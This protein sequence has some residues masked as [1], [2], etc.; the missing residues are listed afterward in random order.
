MGPVDAAALSIV[1]NSLSDYNHC[2]PASSF[3]PPICPTLALADTGASGHYFLPHAP[4]TNINAHAPRTTIRTATGQPLISSGTAA[5]TLRTIPPVSRQAHIVPGLPHNL[6]TIAPLCNAGCT[7]RFTANTLT[8]TDPE[9][10]TILS[11]TRGPNAP[12]L[13]QIDLAP[14]LSPMAL[15]VARPHTART[16]T[17]V[18]PHTLLPKDPGTN[19]TPRHKENL[20]PSPRIHPHLRTHDLPTTQAL[21]AFLHA[22]AG[23]PVKSTWLRAIKNNFYKSWPGLTYTL[24]AKYCPTADATIQG[25]M[26]QPQQHIQSTTHT[27][28]HRQ[29]LPQPPPHTVDIFSIPLNKIFTDDT[30]R[31]HP[32]ARSGN[33]YIMIALHADTN[34]ILVRP[35]PNKHDAH[36]IA[37]YQDIHTRLANANRKPMMHIL[38]NEAS[39]AF[40]QA[41]TSNGCTFQLV[42][43]HVHRRNAAERAIRTFKDHFL[44]ILAGTAPTFPADRWDLLIP[45]AEL[46]LNLLRASHCNPA[47]S[48]WEDLFGPFNFDATPLGPAGCRVLVHNKAT[49]EHSETRRSSIIR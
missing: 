29:T 46:T 15:H 24:I 10:T 23:Y 2:P 28:A 9:G 13:W 1:T 32:R 43:P 36:R 16:P 48:A 22:T 5:T 31:F 45:Q 42:P 4:L 25:H 35:F 26:A 49:A 14:P 11:G 40:Q 34:A 33:Q 12:R 21:V 39:M 20:P 19:L 8:V 47:L 44:S 30:G 38:D 41:I 6:T 7:A 27:A 17:S 3:S 18:M 37:A